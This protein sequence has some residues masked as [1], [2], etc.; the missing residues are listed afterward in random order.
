[1]L[2][3]CERS[4]G[5]LLPIAHVTLLCQDCGKLCNLRNWGFAKQ[6]WRKLLLQVFAALRKQLIN[7]LWPSMLL[8]KGNRIHCQAIVATWK[9]ALGRLGQRIE[10]AWPA[11]TT[12]NTHRADHIVTFK[13]SQ[14]LAHANRTNPERIAQFSCCHLALATQK[15]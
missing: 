2:N 5:Q 10:M 9:Q 13:Q 3:Q 15:L 4:I 12:P 1:M 8:N 11:N 7:R 14:V 6:A